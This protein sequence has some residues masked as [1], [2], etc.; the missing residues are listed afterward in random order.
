M[1]NSAEPMRSST[2]IGDLM[3]TA[4]AAAID[5]ATFSQTIAA[6]TLSATGA[7]TVSMSLSTA[8]ADLTLS[9]AANASTTYRRNMAC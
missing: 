6:L 8:L 2:P 3:L 5:S 9:A 7:G 1:T 4:T